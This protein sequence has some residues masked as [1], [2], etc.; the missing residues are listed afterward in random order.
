MIYSW[1]LVYRLDTRQG[2][3]PDS[4]ILELGQAL[5][6]GAAVSIPT[7]PSFQNAGIVNKLKTNAANFGDP[8]SHAAWKTDPW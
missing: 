2:N 7:L 4:V 8:G 5:T 1:K 3:Y 6:A